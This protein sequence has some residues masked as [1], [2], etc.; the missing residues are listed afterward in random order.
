MKILIFEI[1]FVETAVLSIIYKD[2][3][4]SALTFRKGGGF[5][6]NYKFFFPDHYIVTHK[7]LQL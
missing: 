1:F 4:R 3:F 7:I 6:G 5:S 2:M